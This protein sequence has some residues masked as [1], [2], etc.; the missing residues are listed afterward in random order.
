[1]SLLP[2]GLVVQSVGLPFDAMFVPFIAI[3]PLMDPFRTMVMVL[4][5]AADAASIASATQIP[6]PLVAP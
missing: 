6:A 1:V 3:D 4:G 5:G 2:L